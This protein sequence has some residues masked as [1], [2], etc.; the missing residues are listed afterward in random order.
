MLVIPIP[1]IVVLLLLIPLTTVD[2]HFLMTMFLVQ[3]SIF[4]HHADA[5]LG[6]KNPGVKGLLPQQLFKLKALK[7]IG[8]LPQL[9]Q[10]FVKL[11]FDEF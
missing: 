1:Q 7:A 11:S 4:L 3:I 2:H 5:I 6:V 8:R 10:N 9:G